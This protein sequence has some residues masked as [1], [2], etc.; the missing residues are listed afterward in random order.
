MSA[1]ELCANGGT[2]VVG[3]YSS[4]SVFDNV[5]LHANVSMSLYFGASRVFFVRGALKSF[6][7]TGNTVLD[8]ANTR[9]AKFPNSGIDGVEDLVNPAWV[10]KI[11][12]GLVLKGMTVARGAFQVKDGVWV[13]AEIPHGAAQVLDEQQERLADDMLDGATVKKLT[14][15]ADDLAKRAAAVTAKTPE[16]VKEAAREARLNARNG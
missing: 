2:L 6:P 16:Q 11:E 5:T 14:E 10:D 1:K 7:S 15:T 4:E 9:N 12:K 8:F 3:I 13:K